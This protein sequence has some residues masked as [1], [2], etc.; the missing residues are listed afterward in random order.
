MVKFSSSMHVNNHQNPRVLI[1]FE[2]KI[3]LNAVFSIL[4]SILPY[5]TLEQQLLISMREI[6][7]SRFV[8]KLRTETRLQNHNRKPECINTYF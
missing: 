7:K 4:R 8:T 2:F 5:G 1:E 3:T 6:F